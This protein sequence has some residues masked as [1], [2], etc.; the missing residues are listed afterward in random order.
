MQVHAGCLVGIDAHPVVVEA[1]IAPGLPNFELVGLPERGVR[2]SRVRVKSAIGAQGYEVP[3]R[4]VVVNLAP[5]DLR[6]SGTSFDLAIAIAI[7]GTAGLLEEDGVKETL[8]LGEL[9]L[10]GTL[11]P[12]RGVLPQLRSAK[13]RGLR[14]AVVPRG[15][16]AEA[17]LVDGIEIHLACSLREVVDFLDDTARL[18]SPSSAPLPPRTSP[19]DLIDVRGQESARRALEIA[20]A[21]N[22]HLLLVGPPGAG[23]TMLAKRLPGLLPTPSNDEAL[24]VATIASAAGLAP[25]VARPFR[26]PHHTASAAAMVGGG[27]PVQPGEVTLAHRGVLFLDELPEFRRDVIETLRTTM[28]SGE[29]AIAR[30][31][32]RV[33]L[34]AAPLVVA[35][36]NPCPCGY[37]GDDERLCVC[38]PD[39]VDRY[40]ARISGPLLD[41][42]DLHVRVPRVPTKDIRVAD[43]QEASETVRRRVQDAKRFRAQRPPPRNLDELLEGVD[44]DALS[45]L[46]QA[47]DALKLSARAYAKSLRV[48]RTIAD[49]EAESRVAARHVAEA[50]QYRQ[51]DRRRG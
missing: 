16:E 33:R 27:D 28:E 4:N 15:N 20:A 21:G 11:R 19:H 49:L 23:K 6:K 31:R 13:E 22:H 26:A 44:E 12:I 10:G 7:L 3:K 14:R 35:A 47:I 45:L 8:V 50:V 1:R 51:F 38:G 34:P 29:I 18:P 37:A 24:E 36:M 9:A 2:E 25:K 5:G 42:F 40:M 41:R 43:H 30:A 39:R 17:S 48:A 32:Q 46:D